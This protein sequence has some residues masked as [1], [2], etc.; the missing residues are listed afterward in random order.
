[1]NFVANL[2]D[3]LNLL[4]NIYFVKDVFSL[5][6]DGYGTS[7]MALEGFAT[8]ATG[9]NQFKKKLSGESDKSWYDIYMNL[10]GGIGYVTGV[11]VKTIMRDTKALFLMLGVDVSAMDNVEE[12]QTPIAVIKDGSDLDNL[13]NKFGVNLTKEEA[14]QKK[15]TEKAE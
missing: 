10:F 1:M 11:P 6:K 2:K 7:N 9:I 5:L 8:I 14:K 13:L 12:G 4:N 3:N 15:T